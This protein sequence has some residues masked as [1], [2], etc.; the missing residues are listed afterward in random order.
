MDPVF[1]RDFSI[2]RT[3][4]ERLSAQS[5]PPGGPSQP[6]Q[7]LAQQALLPIPGRLC[8]A[9][10]QRG[11]HPFPKHM[12]KRTFNMAF[13]I[14]VPQLLIPSRPLQ[15]PKHP[16][17]P[18]RYGCSGRRNGLLGIDSAVAAARKHLSVVQK[19][20]SRTYSAGGES[21]SHAVLTETGRNHALLFRKGVGK[22]SLTVLSLFTGV[23]LESKD[24]SW[25]AF[26][27]RA[28]WR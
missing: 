19:M 27:R 13:L 23:V 10:H 24:S 1:Q 14:L 4:A 18:G 25:A 8:P 26:W 5:P 6:S 15:H 11:C 3:H 17:H 12:A 20:H 2:S 21:Q 28:R 22:R 7:H 9:H 16:Y